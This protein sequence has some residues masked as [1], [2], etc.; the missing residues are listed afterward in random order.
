MGLE[1]K[2]L[3]R[4]SGHLKGPGILP[5]PAS[6]SRRQ[7]RRAG[8]ERLWQVHAAQDHG[9][10][11]QGDRRR[12]HPDAGI[13]IGY[14]EQEPAGPE[15]TVRE[16]VKKASA[17]CWPPEA[18]GRGLRRLTPNRM[19]TS[20]PGRRAG[21]LKPSSPPPALR[22]P[23]T[24]GTGRRRAAPAALGRQDRRTVRRR[25][26]PRGLCRLLLSKPDMLLLDEPTNHL[27]R[28]KRWTGWSS[29]CSAS[30]APWWPSPTT[31]TSW[32]TPPSG[33]LNW[34]AGHGIPWKGN[35]SDWLDQK[36]RRLE[37]EQRARTPVPRR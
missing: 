13:K 32:T 8:P 4:Q 15:Q 1:S 9:R 34:T 7:D 28:R 10:P 12:S 29:S 3:G 16:A 21:E 22:T 19:P 27:G 5:G 24:A 31:A 6:S 20:T 35:Y 14:L 2:E 33:F 25:E 37:Q 23:T 17:A 30:P 18:P 11:R 36:E 26:A